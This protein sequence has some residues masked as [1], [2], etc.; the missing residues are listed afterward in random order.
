VGHHQDTTVLTSIRADIS[1]EILAAVL[2]GTATPAAI[3]PE[4]LL[5]H[6]ASPAPTWWVETATGLSHQ[7]T[8]TG[9]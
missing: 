7:E 2:E 1:A 6:T 9:L 4:A 5:E 3:S 8:E